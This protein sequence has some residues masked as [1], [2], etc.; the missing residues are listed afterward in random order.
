M[1][2]FFRRWGKSSFTRKT[3]FFR[4]ISV[5]RRVQQGI[6]M[7]YC[8]EDAGLIVI[9]GLIVISGLVFFPGLIVFPGLMVSL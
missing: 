8:G 1:G 5:R 4:E 7:Y 9:P 6:Y 3:I 2:I